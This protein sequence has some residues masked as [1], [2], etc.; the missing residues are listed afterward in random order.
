MEKTNQNQMGTKPIASLIF[1]MGC[2]PIVSMF[3]QSMYNI[4]DS[5]FV[6]KLGENALTAVSL[7]APIQYI[8]L[9]VSV[10][11][12]VGI[13]SY[14]SRNLGADNIDE[15]NNTVT[16]SMILALAHSVLFIILGLLF[17]KPFFR[18]YAN[19]DAIFSDGC[20]YTYI[21]VLLS[22][23]LF[24]QLTFE[25]VFQ[26]TGKMLL[27]TI[28]QIIG[29]ILN[30]ILD[31]IFIFGWFG[32][33][34]LGVTGAAIATII[35]QIASTV[36]VIIY[37]KN[38]KTVPLLAKHFKLNINYIKEV[39]SI[40]MA[41]G[42]NQLSMMIVQIILNNSLRYYGGLS[43]YGEAIPIA[44]AGITMKVSQ[45]FFSVVIG[46][47][48]GSQPIESFN[49]GAKKY[50]RV[51]YTYILANKAG[52]IISIIA[53]ILFQLF[54]M[55][56]ISLFGSGTEEYYQFA[57][58]FFRIFLFFICIN[59]IQPITSTFFTSIGKPI[60]GI[61]LSL[62][63]QII[64]LLPLIIILPLFFGID[65]II[66]AGPA[67]DLIAAITCLITISI[68]FKNMKQLELVEE[69]QNIHL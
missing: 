55:E 24:F 16:H 34:K 18:I 31:P 62:T 25:K 21:V 14:I 54:P 68:E 9:A 17:I 45:L 51:K 53:F 52:A 4:V 32:I 50:H 6:A 46:L 42:I 49:Y 35:G 12:G 5:I 26:A 67:A 44:C 41:S 2:P 7:A 33:P 23:S 43:I 59:F 58:K 40:G 20:S 13:N 10:G 63:R 37:M 27:P 39:A 19:N 11:V 57:T 64:Y 48:Q 65:G 29:A 28:S 47:S 8:L 22:F 30:I 36:V 66:F 1:T 60:K 38:F 69:H 56:I 61:F 15:A 3:V